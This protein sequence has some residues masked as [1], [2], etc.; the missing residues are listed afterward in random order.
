MFY[1]IYTSCKDKLIRENIIH[2]VISLMSLCH[3]VRVSTEV[4]KLT[5]L[6]LSILRMETQQNLNLAKIIN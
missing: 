2:D 4:N 3:S 6:S 1:S 5:K